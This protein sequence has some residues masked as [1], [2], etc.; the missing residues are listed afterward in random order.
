VT[1]PRSDTWQVVTAQNS[2]L[3]ATHVTAIA[4]D[5][6]GNL[7]F[8]T[9]GG[10]L[11]RRS[12]DGREWQTYRAADGSLI[13]DT[14]GAVTVDATGRVWAVCDARRVDGVEHPGGICTLSPD[15][16]W[17][18]YERSASE[19]CIVALEADRAGTLWLR[20]GGWVGGDSVTICDGVRDGPDRFHAYKWQSFD[21][22]TWTPYDGDRAAVAAWYPQRPDRTGLG[23]ALE[24]DV[25]WM[26]ETVERELTPSSITM[27]GMPNLSLIPGMGSFI[28]HYNLVSYDGQE[29]QK[30]ASTPSP[31]RYGELIVDGEG[32]KWVS[33][34]MLGDIF[35]V[36]G[37]AQLDSEEGDGEWAVF[38]KDTGL[39]NEYVVAM[40]T[41]SRGNV[42][43]SQA[44]GD[45]SRW[46]GAGW[47]HFPAGQ[48]GRAD[49]DLGRCVED[50]Q[51]RLWFPSRAGA[52]V[53]TP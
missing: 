27:P 50:R 42:W 18:V 35:L 31:F 39:V 6:A 38:N 40:S 13:N 22:S 5:T 46:D 29:W 8:A 33:L 17:Q 14:V 53:Y 44:F 26:L 49:K 37:V 9:Y 15:G 4:Q 11:C 3:P 20:C 43:V 24:G 30:R 48:D 52:V 47:T 21:G 32:H 10:G 41:D 23:W 19:P 45:L 12:A 51:G 16:T 1:S 7:W 2:G 34:I 25:V 28:C 36:R